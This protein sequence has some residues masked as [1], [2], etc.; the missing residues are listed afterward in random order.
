MP[1]KRKDSKEGV[2]IA[3]E[4]ELKEKW[5]SEAAKMGL[6]LSDYIIYKVS[7]SFEQLTKNDE[8]K[9]SHHR[10]PTSTE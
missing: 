9:N 8:Y 6:T 7:T 5:K 3:I 2:S 10:E 1:N 4:K